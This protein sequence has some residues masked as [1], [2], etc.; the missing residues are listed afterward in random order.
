MTEY[1]PDDYRLQ[2]VE[3]TGYPADYPEPVMRCPICGAELYSWDMVY[4]R[5]GEIIGCYDCTD[6]GRAED[7][8]DG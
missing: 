2:A 6:S 4:K 3:R 7:V 1:I 8:L 5:N